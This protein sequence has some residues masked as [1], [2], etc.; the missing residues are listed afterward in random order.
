VLQGT[1]HA[2]F[3]AIDAV[4]EQCQGNLEV[5]QFQRQELTQLVGGPRKKDKAALVVLTHPV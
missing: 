3:E 4:M 1:R 5:A 2:E